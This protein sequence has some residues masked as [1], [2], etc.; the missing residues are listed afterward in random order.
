MNP[1]ISYIEVSDCFWTRSSQTH[2]LTAG[3]ADRTLGEKREGA[4]MVVVMN[5]DTAK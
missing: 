5:M 4:E 1:W 2:H 3:V